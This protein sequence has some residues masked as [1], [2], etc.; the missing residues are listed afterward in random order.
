MKITEC[1]VKGFGKLVSKKYSFGAGLNTVLAENG[2]G[3]STLAA[4]ITA[5]LYGL[6]DTRKASLDE[7]DRKKYTPWSTGD[8]GGSLTIEKSGRLLRI[9]R[10]FGK[11]PSDDSAAIFDVN[12]G[13]E[14]SDI[15]EPFGESLFGID[16]DGFLRTVFLSEKS[17]SDRNENKSIS[18]KLAGVSGVSADMGEL[19]SALE[20][21]EERRKYYFK[22]GGSGAISNMQSRAREL[23]EELDILKSKEH[24]LRDSEAELERIKDEIECVKEEINSYEK[25]EVTLERERHIRNYRTQY[26]NMRRR[27]IAEEEKYKKLLTFFEN[28]KPTHEEIDENRR[29]Q[30]EFERVMS[31]EGASDGGEELSKLK[32]FFSCGVSA[33]E[34]EKIYELAKYASVAESNE[35]VEVPEIFTGRIPTAG[36]IDAHTKAV[37]KA[38]AKKGKGA[39]ALTLLLLGAAS[40]ALI[41]FLQVISLLLG[42]AFVLAA[43]AVFFY[44]SN[45]RKRANTEKAAQEFIL[46]VTKSGTQDALATLYE[47]KSELVKYENARMLEINTEKEKRSREEALR[48]VY[49]FLSHFPA[50]S[51]KTL[52][53]AISEIREKQIRYEALLLLEE[54]RLKRATLK[55]REAMQGMKEVSDFLSRF[56]TVTDRPF[57]EI[58]DALN[59]LSVLSSTV[60]SKNKELSDFAKM[61]GA[62][63]EPLSESSLTESE[64]KTK[65]N[66][67]QMRHTA[68]LGEKA[69]LEGQIERDRLDTERI[70]QLS[71]AKQK[72]NAEAIKYEQNLDV[73]LKTQKYL[74]QAHEAMTN[75]YLD[76][77]RL[78]F[79]KYVSDIN[80]SEGE[81]AIDTDF[82]LTRYEGA[83]ARKS[84]S[85]SKGTRELYRLALRLAL[86]DALYASEEAP[87]LILDDP[88]MSFDDKTLERAKSAIKRLAKSRQIIYFTCS[89]SRAV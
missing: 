41:N 25:S 14:I 50:P 35:G 54:E 23:E 7:N 12:L 65:K 70:S 64:I 5:M 87:F 73:I 3:K 22:K 57:D 34:T 53:G 62:L 42:G 72:L 15:D 2:E 51:S 83:A 16:A 86:T 28:G 88:F 59:E 33:E 89:R 24:R 49:D 77:T 78:G 43:G 48:E 47:I 81:F 13:R 56:K 61:N 18:A 36:E 11:K 79:K 67:A 66:N 60:E 32:S 17:L 39:L 19:D 80:G 40:F 10:V 85:Y 84:E 76:K 30:S 63:D 45:K 44:G 31:E 6:S 21:L 26:E 1:Y 74:K 38:R 46:S 37:E 68:L 9:E 55:K 8:F 20:I 71:D 29:K 52:L 27:A 58:R 82:S 4:F 69:L 75:R